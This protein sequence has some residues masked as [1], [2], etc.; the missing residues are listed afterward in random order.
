MLHDECGGVGDDVEAMMMD[1]MPAED[2]K[3]G[4]RL[5]GGLT[6]TQ[7]SSPGSVIFNGGAGQ[8]LGARL[9]DE[10]GR[11]LHGSDPAA[12]IRLAPYQ[13]GQHPG[14][15]PNTTGQNKYGWH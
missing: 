8:P 5:V 13:T 4:R 12:L 2:R 1:E 10:A 15:D 6:P 9:C 7:W 14:R 3:P 11:S